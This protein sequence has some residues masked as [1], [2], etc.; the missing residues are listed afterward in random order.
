MPEDEEGKKT[1]DS[2]GEEEPKPNKADEDIKALRKTL[3]Q[4]S[5]ALR[6]ELTTARQETL[7][8]R[9]KLGAVESADELRAPDLPD[10]TD[11]EVKAAVERLQR[12]AKRES[13]ARRKLEERLALVS[14]RGLDY[15]TEATAARLLLDEDQQPDLEDLIEKLKS[16]PD[17]KSL[18]VAA[19]ELSLERREAAGTKKTKP[20][21]DPGTGSATGKKVADEMRGIEVSTPE[22]RA[23]FQKREAEFRRRIKPK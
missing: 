13:E 17:E 9:G 12:A 5:D 14:E 20:D 11:P 18:A 23:E 10:D 6:K 21:V 19:R 2:K 4:Q 15:A 7:E 1:E 16:E 3:N 8:L 22:G